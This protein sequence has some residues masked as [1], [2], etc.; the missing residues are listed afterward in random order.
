MTIKKFLSGELQLLI[1]RYEMAR[2][3]LGMSGF[4]IDSTEGLSNGQTI[5]KYKS[6]DHYV[7]HQVTKAR[8][9]SGWK[10]FRVSH[11]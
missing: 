6:Y 4:E 5:R 11:F 10:E 9:L 8:F 2:I 1:M 7:R 3:R